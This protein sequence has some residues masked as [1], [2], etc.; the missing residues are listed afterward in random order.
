MAES[1]SGTRLQSAQP[2]FDSGFRLVFTCKIT[3]CPVCHR[4]VAVRP[5]TG[6]LFRHGE[7]AC[8]P[9]SDQVPEEVT[10]R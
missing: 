3:E 6:R 2:R 4:G 9:G 10:A 5:L 1:G 8:C 7:G